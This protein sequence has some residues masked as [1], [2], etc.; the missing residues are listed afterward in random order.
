MATL[1]RCKG[2]NFEVLPKNKKNFTREEIEEF[3][4][5]SNLRVEKVSKIKSI[6]Y[7][8]TPRGDFNFLNEKAM[9]LLESNGKNDQVYGDSIYL[10]NSEVYFI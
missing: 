9:S 3:L 2:K 6:I 5:S 1:L 10:R 7:D 4:G 8:D